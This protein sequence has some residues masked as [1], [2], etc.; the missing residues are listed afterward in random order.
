MDGATLDQSS[1]KDGSVD[2]EAAG[3]ESDGNKD[4]DIKEDASGEENAEDDAKDQEQEG[5]DKGEKG[6]GG[7][8]NMSDDERFTIIIISFSSSCTT[9]YISRFIS[10]NFSHSLV[11]LP[12]C[13]MNPFIAFKETGRA[14]EDIIKR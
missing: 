11:T 12:F 7:E 10:P 8:E 13:L 14:G 1:V 4:D 9:R 5:E 6:N 2:L 3:V